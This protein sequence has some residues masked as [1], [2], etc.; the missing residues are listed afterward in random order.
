MV[1]SCHS[2]NGT[3]QQIL[4]CK[5]LLL[6]LSALIKTYEMDVGCA[7][8]TFRSSLSLTD[9]WG[10]WHRV[11]EHDAALQKMEDT[12]LKADSFS[13]GPNI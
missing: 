1:Q 2:S 6:I 7:F 12:V 9:I 8:W 13:L 4:A 11:L 3:G 5:S 10:A